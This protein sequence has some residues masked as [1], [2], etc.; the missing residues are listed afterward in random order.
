M[1]LEEMKAVDIRMVDPETLV[2]I[3]DVHIDTSLPKEERMRSF[4]KQIKNPYVFKYK[5][6]VIKTSFVNNGLTIEDC[7]E[8]Y[9]RNR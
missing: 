1:T 5:D 6:V 4:L 2:D 8:D 7:L 3:R 9:I